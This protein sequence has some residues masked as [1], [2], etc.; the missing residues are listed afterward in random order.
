MIVRGRTLNDWVRARLGLVRLEDFGFGSKMHF[1]YV[2]APPGCRNPPGSA[3]SARE[4]TF[5]A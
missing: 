3:E 2:I 4:S 1:W 5:G